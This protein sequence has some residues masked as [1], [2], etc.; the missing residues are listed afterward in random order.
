MII[1]F[2]I[3]FKNLIFLDNKF[4]FFSDFEILYLLL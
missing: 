4:P 3:K 2:Y 1:F